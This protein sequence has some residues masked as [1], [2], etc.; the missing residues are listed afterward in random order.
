M[1]VRTTELILAFS[2]SICIDYCLLIAGN[3]VDVPVPLRLT[4]LSPANIVN[5]LASSD[6]QQDRSAI[7][8]PVTSFN[9]SHEN[10]Y[11]ASENIL[12]RI[13]DQH[14]GVLMH[15]NDNGKRLK[16]ENDS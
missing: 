9:A 13:A 14:S 1:K 5:R 3:S 12:K 7:A 16:T 11:K 10:S 6:P 2:L 4:S 15:D 8:V